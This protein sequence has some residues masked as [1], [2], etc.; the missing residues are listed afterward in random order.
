VSQP[1]L[2]DLA[3][4]AIRVATSV[5]GAREIAILRQ[6]AESALEAFVTAVA[7]ADPAAIDDARYALV[8]LIDE[9]ALAATSPVRAAWLDRPLQLALYDSFSAGEEFYS[10][11]ERWRHP[12]KPEDAMVLEVFHTC[13]A[14][15]FRGRL[16]GEDGETARRQLLSAC[17]GEILACRGQVAPPA[18]IAPST[19]NL[20][21]AAGNPWRW[22]GLPVWMVPVLC[23]V[24]VS[25]V[26]MAGRWWV[27]LTAAR[28]AAELR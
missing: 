10:R 24:G 14:L 20:A 23:V 15:G 27:A 28:L 2:V 1:P 13:L 11:L 9:R 6:Q 3:V 4:D 25:A 18:P 7:G 26:I 8:A 17:A 5:G 21:A 19:S 22:R 12:R 16:A